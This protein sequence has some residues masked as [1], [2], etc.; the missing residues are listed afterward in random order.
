MTT[1]KEVHLNCNGGEPDYYPWEIR[2]VSISLGGPADDNGFLSCEVFSPQDE[3][4]HW[5][6]YLNKNKISG[7]CDFSIETMDIRSAIAFRDFL[8][9]ALKDIQTV[10][11]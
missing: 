9:Y 1:E 10:K 5:S 3:L 2:E 11:K 7:G 6:I 8:N 4:I